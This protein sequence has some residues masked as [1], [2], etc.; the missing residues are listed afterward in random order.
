MLTLAPGWATASTPT[1][2]PSD[3]LSKEDRDA[4][5]RFKLAQMVELAASTA[6]R[7]T[8][9]HPRLQLAARTQLETSSG[10]RFSVL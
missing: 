1:K 10:S 5:V 8:A 6:S 9:S 2:T 7:P 4:K 3:A